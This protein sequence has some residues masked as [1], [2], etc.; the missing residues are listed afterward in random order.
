[1]SS[2][3]GPI[4]IGRNDTVFE[5]M[6]RLQK[7]LRMVRLFRVVSRCLFTVPL[8]LYIVVWILFF[9]LGASTP[10]R[11][12]HDR[13]GLGWFAVTLV[14]L[15]YSGVP[16]LLVPLGA[17]IGFGFWYRNLESRLGTLASFIR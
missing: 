14:F 9:A 16:L 10:S 1:M 5:Q 3:S 13:E 7:N 15:G 12:P 2:A 6:T 11:S 4:K 8:I 17:W